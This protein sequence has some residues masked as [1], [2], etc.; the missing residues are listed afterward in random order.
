[1]DNE[2]LE[3]TDAIPITS[4][5]IAIPI[6]AEMPQVTG[7]ETSIT[8]KPTEIFRLESPTVAELKDDAG[9]V[10]HPDYHKTDGGGKPLKVRGKFV[11]IKAG[12]PSKE[13]VEALKLSERPNT[14]KIST[15][16]SAKS[17]LEGVEIPKVE[18]ETEDQ[19][20]PNETPKTA[21]ERRAEKRAEMLS[22]YSVTAKMYMG[23]LD[24]IAEG[25]FGPDARLDQDDKN[26]LEPPMVAVMEEKGEIPL[27][28]IQ[29]LCVVALS[30]AAKKAKHT[31]VRE[32]FGILVY[33]I[34]N[35]FKKKGEN[36]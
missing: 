15:D 4:E 30:I 25:F 36:N 23:V 26:M 17:K 12:R 20:Q 19:A 32:R 18:I 6:A 24:G 16:S 1:M 11:R 2:P 28:P 7:E 35:M 27:T 5:E 34:K 22:Q 29:L 33:R 8:E 31:T 3:N 9:I 10:F 14:P 21:A 13:E